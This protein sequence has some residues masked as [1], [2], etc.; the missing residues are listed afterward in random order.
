MSIFD[1]CYEFTDAD[2]VRKLGLYPY[3]REISSEQDTWV[4]IDGNRVLMLGS[5]S[6]MGLTSDPRVK[7]KSIEA[8]KKYGTGCAGSR[9]LNGT[10][11]IH[12]QL[13]DE[14]AEFLGKESALLYSTGF[15]VNQGVLSTLVGRKDYLFSDRENHASIVEGQRLAF[16]KC[17][18]FKHNDIEDLKEQ[19]ES[20]PLDANKLIVFDGVFSMEGDIAPLPE[21]VRLAKKYNAQIMV[22]DAHSLGVLGPNGEGTA[23]HYGLQDDVDLIMSTFSKSLAALGGF[24]AGDEDVIDYLRHHSRALIFSAS[25]TPAAIGA[26]REALRIIKEEPERREKL[27]KNTEHMRDGLKEMGYDIG[28]TKTPIIPIIVGGM[29]DVFKLCKMLQDEGVF[30][31]PVVP[32]ATTPNRSLIRISFMATHSIEQ[33][34]FALEKLEKC[35]KA[36]GLI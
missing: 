7:Q 35:G 11:D 3:F 23:H 4:E 6:Y 20:V 29:M 2:Q 31:N 9:F 14:I 8:V 18:K 15:Q 25:P 5:N 28:V 12:R 1:K 16:G 30:V 17:Q 36:L 34:D 27:W 19:L 22:D 13:E 24:I 26:V 33:L 21:V 32:P 10:L